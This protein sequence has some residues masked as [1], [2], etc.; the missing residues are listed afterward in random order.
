M[1][2]KPATALTADPA[3][4]PPELTARPLSRRQPTLNPIP[5][6]THPIHPRSPQILPPPSSILVSPQRHPAAALSL[7]TSPNPTV[8]HICRQSQYAAVSVCY[9]ER[10]QWVAFL[11]RDRTQC[12]TGSHQ[13][14][15]SSCRERCLVDANVQPCN[16]VSSWPTIQ[17]DAL[18]GGGV[19]ESIAILGTA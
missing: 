19:V 1:A 7:G 4:S 18:H 6:Q 13:H 17:C 9:I 11:E 5:I 3:P 12:P 2:N 16:R 8:F 10:P 14:W 15:P